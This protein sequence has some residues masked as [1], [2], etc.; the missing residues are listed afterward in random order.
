[1][2]LDTAQLRLWLDSYYEGR[3]TASIMDDPRVIDMIRQAGVTMDEYEEL[4]RQ[5][6]ATVEA[7]EAAEQEVQVIKN[8][9]FNAPVYMWLLHAFFA[10]IMILMIYKVRY[11][12]MK[13]QAYI[14]G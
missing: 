12:R 3:Y 13:I 10:L 11:S 9:L 2:P 1:P 14:D 5:L 8:A 4:L 7:K 6:I